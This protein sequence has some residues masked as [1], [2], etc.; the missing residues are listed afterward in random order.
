MIFV[1][2]ARKL[3]YKLIMLIKLKI[4]IPLGSPNNDTA[5][6]MLILVF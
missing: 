3:R 6:L 5:K 4:L 2:L 1:S